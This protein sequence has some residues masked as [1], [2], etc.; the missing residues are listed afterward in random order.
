MTNFFSNAV[1]SGQFMFMAEAEGYDGLV[2]TRLTKINAAA[3]DVEKIFK[4][5]TT[6]GTLSAIISSAAR[7]HGIY[8]L[9][10]QEIEY[11]KQRIHA[12]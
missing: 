5:Q 12:Y 7:T 8:D 4:G 9:T 10:P 2:N 1:K 3:R 11:I 6:S